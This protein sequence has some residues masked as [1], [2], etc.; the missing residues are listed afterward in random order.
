M[1]AS[2]RITTPVSDRAMISVVFRSLTCPPV[3]GNSGNG[4]AVGGMDVSA[5][6]TGVSVFG[7]GVLVGGTDVS[8]GGTDVSVGVADVPVGVGVGVEPADAGA[9][10]QTMVPMTS[11]IKTPT[12]PLE[13]SLGTTDNLL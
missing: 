11:R 8:V 10:C 3:A 5:G 13:I 2:R 1:A 12:M 6:G 4:V 9:T 7:T